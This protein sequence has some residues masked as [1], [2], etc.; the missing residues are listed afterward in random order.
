MIA[1]KI[2]KKEGKET[3]RTKANPTSP[4][5]YDCCWVEPS[6]NQVCC[7]GVCCT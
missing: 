3:K 1:K 4:T 2:D 6:C 5:L 7:G